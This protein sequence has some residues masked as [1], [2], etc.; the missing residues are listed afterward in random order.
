MKIKTSQAPELLMD[1][2]RAGKVPMMHG[3]PGTA[4]SSIAKQLA[5]EQNLLVIDLRLSQS[6]P[7]DL[8]G[9]PFLNA[10][11]TKAGYVPMDTFPIEGDPLPVKV[12]GK[13][14]PARKTASDAKWLVEPIYYAG[15]LLLLDEFNSAPIS[16]QAAAYKLVLDKEVGQFKLHKKVA[17][18]AAGNLSTDGAIVNRLSTAMQSRLVHFQVEMSP[19]DWLIW[20][21]SNDMDY[22]VT[23]YIGFKPDALHVFD[24]N[25][26]DFTFPCART[27]EFVSDII[28][29]WPEI[30]SKKYPII[31]G[32]IGDGISREFTGF[33]NIFEK[34]PNIDQILAN[35]ES[36]DM[37]VGPDIKYAI[38][39]LISN[40]VTDSN[41]DKL[42]KCIERLPAEFQ[43]ICLQSS[44]RRCPAI[45]DNPIWKNWLIKNAQD[46]M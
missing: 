20:A 4:K 43:V 24:A 11:K 25:H 18:I 3:S 27:W 8:G 12:A 32:C 29:P 30:E 13:L 5:A 42:I 6:D 35:P 14:N 7:T 40:H 39:N 41:F 38:S 45:G 26:N 1:V 17:C 36:V 21:E 28:K 16:V 23:A 34:L 37:N 44:F 2:L 9:F 46:L 10:D 22:R 33:C 19:K 31:D 15:W